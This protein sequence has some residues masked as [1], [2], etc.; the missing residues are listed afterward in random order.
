MLIV[1]FQNK[2]IDKEGN[3]IVKK[4]VNATAKEN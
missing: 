3:R 2:I 1:I 4:T